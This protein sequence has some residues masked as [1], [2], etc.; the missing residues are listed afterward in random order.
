VDRADF[1]EPA[2]AEVEEAAAAAIAAEAAVAEALQS[3]GEDAVSA[4]QR[5]AET[6]P[7]NWRTPDW[8]PRHI[9]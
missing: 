8:M 1:K 2:A 7:I 5:R 6:F 4:R 9:R 3:G